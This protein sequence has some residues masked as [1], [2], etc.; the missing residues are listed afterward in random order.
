LQE[1]DPG[2]P[3]RCEIVASERR[4]SG[5]TR[6]DD[7]CAANV[8]QCGEN[9]RSEHLWPPSALRQ[10]S[11]DPQ[12]GDNRRPSTLVN[13][14]NT[15]AR[16]VRRQISTPRARQC[17]WRWSGTS[18]EGREA[19]LIGH[20]PRCREPRSLLRDAPRR[21]RTVPA[22]GDFVPRPVSGNGT[23]RRSGGYGPCAT[24]AV[25][26]EACDC[27]RGRVTLRSHISLEAI[28]HVRLVSI[29]PEVVRPHLR[30]TART[31]NLAGVCRQLG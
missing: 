2:A 28:E 31:V 12:G 4:C 11:P 9:R 20:R 5:V 23:G 21:R 19:H 22:A 26:R 13:W 1:V 18:G 3:L 30:R 17:P 6:F 7:E 24:C 8:P 15:F 25:S 29:R 14:T 27:R 16:S 10:V